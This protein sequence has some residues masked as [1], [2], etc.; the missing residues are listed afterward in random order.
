[1]QSPQISAWAQAGA[2]AQSGSWQS[3]RPSPSSSRP[4]VQ[5]SGGFG[6]QPSIGVAVQMPALQASV[7]QASWSW[8]APALQVSV[9]QG[10]P[11]SVQSASAMQGVQLGS[12]VDSQAPATQASAVQA[13]ESLQS[14]S[15]VQPAH[16]AGARFTVTVA[17]S[18]TLGA[19][20][21]NA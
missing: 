10:L 20:V 13:F 9:V 14:A 18:W 21:A 4:F 15:V 8:Q 17:S 7:V 1:M 3:T 2:F 19:F 11:S 12:V 6:V 5:S 16:P